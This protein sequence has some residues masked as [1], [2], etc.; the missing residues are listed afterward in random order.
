MLAI[1]DEQEQGWRSCESTRLP[2]M[3][4]GLNSHTQHHKW[5]EFVGSLL[6]SKRFLSSY[7]SFPLSSKTNIWFD[8]EF[9]WFSLPRSLWAGACNSTIFCHSVFIDRFIFRSNLLWMRFPWECHNQLQDSNW[10]HCVTGPDLPFSHKRKGVL[11]IDQS[12]KMPWLSFA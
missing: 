2:P 8:L 6:Y 3:C 11:N 12:V 4:P 5:T 7:S 1:T 9:I 10:R